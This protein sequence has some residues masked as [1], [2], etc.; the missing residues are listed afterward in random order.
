MSLIK[1]KLTED[2]IKLV[3]QL[4]INIRNN[5]ENI[6]YIIID[7]KEPFGSKDIF[8]DIFLILYGKPSNG[9][10]NINPWDKG[11]KPWT[12]EQLNYMKK[13]L[14]ELPYALDIILYTGKFEV[15]FYKTK[16]YHRDWK[17]IN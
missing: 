17:K 8:D 14:I 1:F 5:D 15:G 3:R 6:D 11:Q 12:D 13:L 9:E 10:L 2:H 7:N 4:K 16:S